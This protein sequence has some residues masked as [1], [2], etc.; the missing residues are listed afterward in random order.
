MCYFHIA[1]KL[2]MVF[3]HLWCRGTTSVEK[4]LPTF[5]LYGS[6][7]TTSFHKAQFIAEFIVF[8][9][10]TYKLVNKPYFYKV[11]LVAESLEHPSMVRSVQG[12]IPAGSHFLF[13]IFYFFYF[14]GLGL[15]ADHATVDCL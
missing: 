13:F 2:V 6:Y 14:Y 8:T 15:G 7:I 4:P 9:F 11:I 12:S 1:E 3:T 5:Q 10:L